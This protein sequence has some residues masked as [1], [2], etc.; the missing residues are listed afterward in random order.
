MWKLIT[1]T[2]QGSQTLKWTKCIVMTRLL[3]IL[4]YRVYQ[5]LMLLPALVIAIPFIALGWL[6]LKTKGNFAE[7]SL[8]LSRI[9][10]YLG[11]KTRLFYY[12][13]LL[14][15]VGEKVTFKYGSFC[16]Y[17]NTKIGNRVMIGYFNTL[18]MVNIGD[19]VM[20]GGNVN[21]LSGLH[22]HAFD[23]PNRLMWDTPSGGR[24]MVNIGSDVWIGSNAVIGSDVGNRCVVAAGA[25]V[26]KQVNDHSLVGGNPAKLIRTI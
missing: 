19:N 14:L 18:G 23:D 12:K 24:M 7:P 3:K 22:H 1:E 26:V 4:H 21:I 16:S 5:K 2:L 8:V 17:R 11:E 13:A 10:F 20:I 9:P 15:S 25:V 6:S